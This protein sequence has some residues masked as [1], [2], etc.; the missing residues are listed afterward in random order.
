IMLMDRTAEIFLWDGVKDEKVVV[1][2][3]EFVRY[4]RF[5]QG[6]VTLPGEQEFTDSLTNQWSAYR[7][8]FERFFTLSAEG[9]G[10]WEF[11]RNSLLPHSQQV[12]DIAQ[13]IIDINLNNMVSTDG[14]VRKEG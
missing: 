4:L 6:N 11:Y 3:R 10:R 1:T 8:L 5:Q 14:Q 7:V 12:S 13:R 2:E 9:T